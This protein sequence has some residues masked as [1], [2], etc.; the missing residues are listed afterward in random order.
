MAK[1]V[2][3]RLHAIVA[4]RVR[5]GR[6]RL[7]ISQAAL[8]ERLG[9][10]PGYVAGIELGRK[11]PSAR[12]MERIAEAYGIE[13]FRLLVPLDGSLSPNAREIAYDIGDGLK[14]AMENEFNDLLEKYLREI[15]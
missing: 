6:D 14:K 8:A 1:N 9:V 15:P 10:S 4:Y 12:L 7:G 13:P 5:A 3:T 11:Y 2:P